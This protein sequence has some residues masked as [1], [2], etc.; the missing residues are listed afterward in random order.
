VNF[1]GIDGSFAV[2]TAFV[3]GF[4]NFIFLMLT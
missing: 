4:A 2:K 1:L 3:V